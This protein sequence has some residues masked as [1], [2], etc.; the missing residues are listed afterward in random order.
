VVF[1]LPVDIITPFLRHS[2][3][4]ES[5]AGALNERR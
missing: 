4:L 2:E 5:I 3:M 1:P